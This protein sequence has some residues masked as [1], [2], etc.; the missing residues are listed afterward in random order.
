MLPPC[1]CGT[2]AAC[3][4]LPRPRCA[5]VAAGD[6]FAPLGRLYHTLAVEQSKSDSL[7]KTLAAQSTGQEEGVVSWAAAAPGGVGS[8]PGQRRTGDVATATTGQAAGGLPKLPLVIQ[9]DPEHR[10][11]SARC[12]GPRCPRGA[13]GVRLTRGGSYEKLLAEYDALPGK[14][15]RVESI[16]EKLAGEW[17]SAK[18][19][20]EKTRRS[21]AIRQEYDKNHVLYQQMSERHSKLYSYLSKL[22]SVITTYRDKR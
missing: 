16:F 1:R 8:R 2:P 7:V 22:R 10:D 3:R 19:A 6:D 21:R 4:P 20:E 15:Q 18:T 12:A 17:K 14:M 13:R 11:W 9:M 5:R